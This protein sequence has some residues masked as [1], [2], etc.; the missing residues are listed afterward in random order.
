MSSTLQTESE[1]SSLDFQLVLDTIDLPA[2]ALDSDNRVIAWDEQIADLLGIDAETVLGE[3]GL[4]DIA[5]DKPNKQTL[6]E[7]VLDAPESAHQ[8]FDDIGLAKEEYA[9]LNAGRNNVYE[10]TSTLRGRDIWFVA[11][12]VYRDGELVGVQSVLT[13]RHL[14]PALRRCCHT[15][16]L[17][18]AHPYGAG[19]NCSG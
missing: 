2:F 17:A 7:K 6:A 15:C 18:T 5:Y 11:T 16:L 3:Q 10:D 13:R 8:R 19:C 12:P 1:S 4:G 14:R 9:L